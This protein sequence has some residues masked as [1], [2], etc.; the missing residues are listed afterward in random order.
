VAS[1][2]GELNEI[3]VHL[4]TPFKDQEKEILVYATALY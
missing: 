4:L 2:F 1:L 3:K